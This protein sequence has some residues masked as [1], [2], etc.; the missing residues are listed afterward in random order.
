MTAGA[1]A[2]RATGAI[3][4]TGDPLTIEEIVAVA[5]H[6]ARVVVAPTVRERMKPARDLVERLDESGDV[7]Y[8]VTTGFGALA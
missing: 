6:G 3:V 1:V 7:A 5:R 2:A 8:G 4:L